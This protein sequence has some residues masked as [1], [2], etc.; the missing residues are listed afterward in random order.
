MQSL[1]YELIFNPL[2]FRGRWSIW[3]KGMHLGGLVVHFYEVSYRNI[4]WLN[5]LDSLTYKLKCE[6]INV[7]TFTRIGSLWLKRITVNSRSARSLPWSILLKKNCI[8]FERLLDHLHKLVN[9]FPTFSCKTQENCSN[10]IICKSS[11]VKGTST[12]WNH[13]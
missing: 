8:W 12:V 9:W 5:D 3:P 13:L 4:N 1:A 11:K 10:H 6:L 2:R 7:L